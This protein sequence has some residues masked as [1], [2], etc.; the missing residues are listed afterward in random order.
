MLQLENKVILVTGASSGIGRHLALLCARRQARV[1]LSARRHERLLEVQ[2]QIEGEGLLKPM[3][4]ECDVGDK[5][6]V[7]AL[8]EQIEDHWGTVDVL[9]NNAGRG[10]YGS[11]EKVEWAELESVVQTN[12]LGVVYCTR[13]FLPG[14]LEKGRGNLVFISSVLGELPSPQHAVYG[15]TK[16][17]VTGL[18]ESLEH[19]YRGRGIKVTLVEPGLVQSEFAG[20]SG[21]P[22]ERFR[23][24]PSKSA[25]EVA[26][27]TLRAIER[28]RRHYVAATSA[29]AVIV[30]RRYFPGAMHWVFKQFFRR[31]YNL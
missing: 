23:K 9:V 4:V 30:L 8:R 12:L 6:Q 10:A 28:E 21:T 1:V 17:A 19:E 16:F 5:A 27:L 11:F 20:I 14:M 2:R 7:E 29:H 15:A 22:L 26:V 25:A 18:A 3:L 31:R 24:V 13:A